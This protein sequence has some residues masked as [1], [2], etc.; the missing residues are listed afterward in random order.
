MDFMYFYT[1]WIINMK[2]FTIL[3]YIDIL[4]WLIISKNIKIKILILIIKK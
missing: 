1:I 2:I 4:S 3:I